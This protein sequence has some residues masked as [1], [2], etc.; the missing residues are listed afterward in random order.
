[1]R[2]VVRR[3]ARDRTAIERHHWP[4]WGEARPSIE[5][6][7]ARPK[8]ICLASRLEDPARVLVG[9]RTEEEFETSSDGPRYVGKIRQTEEQGLYYGLTK[10]W[11]LYEWEAMAQQGSW[12]VLNGLKTEDEQSN[13]PWQTGHD[14]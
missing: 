3:L 10:D 13:K 7:T 12:I 5:R 11:I 2:R 4:T 1:M 6:A 14:E 9:E 8:Q